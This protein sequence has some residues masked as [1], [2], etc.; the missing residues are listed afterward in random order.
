MNNLPYDPVL[1]KEN[2]EAAAEELIREARYSKPGDLFVLGCST[3][4]V[5]G[6][7]I[8]KG[9]SEETGRLII[10]NLLPVIRRHGLYLAVQGCEHINRA[11]V[12]ERDYLLAH[13]LEEVNVLP[14]LHA[15]G[16]ASM[17]AWQLFS[18][19]AMAEHIEASL[20]MDIGDTEIGMHVRFVQRPVRLEVTHIGGARLTALMY[21]PK[22]VGGERALHQK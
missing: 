7:A 9:S 14:A 12:V 17:A 1:L 6:L 5:L 21:R 20:G 2:L 3:S 15:G 4:E 22:L 16:A 11:L 13:D 18:D 8:G 10:E 19:P